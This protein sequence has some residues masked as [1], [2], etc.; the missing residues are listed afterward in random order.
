MKKAL[1]DDSDSSGEETNLVTN[2]E[3]AKTYNQIRKKQLLKKRKKAAN[4][5][6]THQ[7]ET[8][9]FLNLTIFSER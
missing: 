3:Y 9:R 6:A 1:F 2:K 4:V 7:F 8:Y 5:L